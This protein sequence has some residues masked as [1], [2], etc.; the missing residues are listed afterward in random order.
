MDTIERFIAMGYPRDIV[1]QALKATTGDLGLAGEVMESLM[2]SKG[3]PPNYEGV[4][5]N[6]D[7]KDLVFLNSVDLTH[8]AKS[9]AEQDEKRKAVKERKR[10]EN[11]HGWKRMQ[12]RKQFLAAWKNA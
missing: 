1:I 7:D 3:I 4:W 8:L 10:L 11:K 12:E 2:K 6:R 9:T 5:T